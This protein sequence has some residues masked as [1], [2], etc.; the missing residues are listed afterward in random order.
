MKGI[1]LT[2]LERTLI[3]SITKESQWDHFS[4]DF[5][6]E[7]EDFTSYAERDCFLDFC[8]V[9][10]YSKLFNIDVKT[11]KG[12][13]GSLQKKELISIEDGEGWDLDCNVLVIDEEQFYT[14]KKLLNKE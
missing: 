2:D 7:F 14:I 4:L 1:K 10:D 6:S 3:L 13:L 12:V 11:I 8:D 5:N 9:V